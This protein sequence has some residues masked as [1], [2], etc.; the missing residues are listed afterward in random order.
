MYH[1]RVLWK[2]AQEFSNWRRDFVKLE[3]KDQKGQFVVRNERYLWVR[4]R[5]FE[6]KL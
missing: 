4:R 2:P 3:Q 5:N 1:R 6:G